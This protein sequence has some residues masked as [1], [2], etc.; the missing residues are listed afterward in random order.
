MTTVLPAKPL[1]QNAVAGLAD[2]IEA[3]GA[4]DKL[5]NQNLCGRFHDRATLDI[6]GRTGISVFQSKAFSL[7]FSLEMVERHP[8]GSQAFLPMYQGDYLVVLAD[9]E[10]GAPGVPMAFI[11]GAGQGVNIRRGVWHGV[12]CP[13]SAPGL[14]AVVDRVSDGVNL[15]EHRFET[16]YVIKG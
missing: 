5:I 9:D 8:L 15:E 3:T 2:V 12:L 16:P 14:F 6:E 7:P 4:P 10:G 1:T 11:A 13:L